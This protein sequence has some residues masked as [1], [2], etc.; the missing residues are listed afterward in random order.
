MV[1]IE[2]KSGAYEAIAVAV[3]AVAGAYTINKIPYIN[4]HKLVSAVIGFVLA[5]LGASWDH[6]IGDFI[7]GYGIG[8]FVVEMPYILEKVK[9]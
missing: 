4:E 1:K 9:V 3:G 7:M 2:Y 6:Y 8:A 5:W